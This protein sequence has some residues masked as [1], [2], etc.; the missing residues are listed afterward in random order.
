MVLEARRLLRLP[1]HTSTTNVPG[2]G[3]VEASQVT[4][5]LPVAASVMATDVRSVEAVASKERMT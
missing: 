3:E 1:T 2:G 5:T 4:A